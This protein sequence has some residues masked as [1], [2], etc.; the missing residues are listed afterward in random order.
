MG[1]WLLV[2]HAVLLRAPL[3]Q[4]NSATNS[5]RQRALSCHCPG[6]AACESRSACHHAS[7]TAAAGATNSLPQ[8]G[9]PSRVP[10]NRT[11][12]MRSF[13]PRQP[14]LRP[15]IL[16]L[17]AAVEHAVAGGPAATLPPLAPS[18]HSYASSPPAT[19]TNSA[20][21][22]VPPPVLSPPPPPSHASAPLSL[23]SPQP[24]DFVI[25]DATPA[26]P[27][28]AVSQPAQPAEW[29]QFGNDEDMPPPLPLQLVGE[30]QQAAGS[31][32]LQ[33]SAVVAAGVVIPTGT[34]R[35]W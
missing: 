16:Q 3:H 34:E 33:K 8:H 13:L 22:P 6:R 17:K 20:A 23:A 4:R 24:R 29:A 21:A 7:A 27:P 26:S 9:M 28:R 32:S 1:A 18:P 30:E 35:D 10:V 2:V 15:T 25:T 14:H 19:S 11:A 31:S 5:Q 12:H